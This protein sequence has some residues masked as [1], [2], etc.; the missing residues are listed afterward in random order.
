M[1]SRRGEIWFA[2]LGEPSGHEQ[3]GD[4]EVVVLQVDQ[5]NHLSTTVVVP[6]SRVTHHAGRA[7]TVQL[8]AAETGLTEDTHA[9]CLHVRV[10]DRRKLRRK[11]GQVSPT[12]LSEIEAT[13]AFVLGLP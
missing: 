3:A 9:L 11:A 1:A 10:L 13:V 6:T 7:T 4:R 5:L 12:K 8:P 2:D